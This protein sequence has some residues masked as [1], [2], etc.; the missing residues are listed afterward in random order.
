MQIKDNPYYYS[1]ANFSIEGY[2]RI[3]HKQL[4][5]SN[6][7]DIYRKTRAI[8]ACAGSLRI[9]SLVRFL[10]LLHL[11]RSTDTLVLSESFARFH[12]EIAKTR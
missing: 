1:T 9:F 12:G 6:M 5:V 8:V 4:A 10:F 11:A 7:E 2:I 3:R